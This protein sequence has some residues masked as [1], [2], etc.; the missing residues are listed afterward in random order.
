MHFIWQGKAVRSSAESDYA[1]FPE[2]CVVWFPIGKRGLRCVSVMMPVA[3]QR[4]QSR[5]LVVMVRTIP[6]A[7]WSTK[8]V[9]V[10]IRSQ[11]LGTQEQQE[12]KYQNGFI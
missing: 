3:I 8:A 11:F 5:H 4:I 12:E 2:F 10:C 7:V 1:L 6:K 9:V